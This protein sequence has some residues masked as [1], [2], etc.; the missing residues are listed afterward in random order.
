MVGWQKAEHSE[1]CLPTRERGQKPPTAEAGWLDSG[2]FTS[3]GYVSGSQKL[4]DRENERKT[5][6]LL[7]EREF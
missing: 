3:L 6:G 4:S 1:N 7:N 5:L 2:V